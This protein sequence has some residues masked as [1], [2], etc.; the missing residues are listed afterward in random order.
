MFGDRAVYVGV[1]TPLSPSPESGRNVQR[2]LLIG[3]IAS[4]HMVADNP[5]DLGALSSIVDRRVGAKT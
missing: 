5:V 2:T 4:P 1:S 3:K